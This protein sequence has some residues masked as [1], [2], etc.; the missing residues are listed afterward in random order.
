MT[1][2][3]FD[4]EKAK[5]NHPIQTRDGRPA[6]FIACAEVKDNRGVVVV[7]DGYY[8]CVTKE[9]CFYKDG[10]LSNADLF[11]APVKHVKWIN[12]Y[13]NESGYTV[14]NKTWKSQDDA[15]SGAVGSGNRIAC[16]QIEYTEGQGL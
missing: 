15:H 7:I 6:K 12:V 16:I 1:L 2:L 13:K 14:G 5:A 9:G 11:M 10:K 3:P 8:Q 4:L